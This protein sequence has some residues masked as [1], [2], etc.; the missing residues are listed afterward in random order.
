MAIGPCMCGD[1]ACYSCGPAQGYDPNDPREDLDE[2]LNGITLQAQIDVADAVC[3]SYKAI[4][5]AFETVP[6]LHDTLVEFIKR[7]E[8]CHE[9]NGEGRYYNHEEEVEEYCKFCQG[10]GMKRKVRNG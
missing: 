6:I 10:Y 2:W 1:P 7:T 8:R 4:L 5:D 3:E 9:C